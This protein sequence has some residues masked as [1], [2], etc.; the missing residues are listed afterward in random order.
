MD[1]LFR[2]F[3]VLACL[4][5]PTAAFAQEEEEFDPGSMIIGH[6]TDAHS[7]HFYDYTGSDDDY[8]QKGNL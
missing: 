1:R 3:M 5:L 4:A 7:W 8:S 2:L 6:V